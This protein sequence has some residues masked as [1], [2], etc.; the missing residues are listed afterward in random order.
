MKKIFIYAI[1]LIGTP[2]FAVDKPMSNAALIDV[3]NTTNQPQNIRIPS[4]CNFV[5][6]P[7]VSVFGG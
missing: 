6:A 5:K 2:S 3:I 4:P 7:L 1:F